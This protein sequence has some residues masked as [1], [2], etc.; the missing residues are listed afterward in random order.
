MRMGQGG[1]GCDGVVSKRGAMDSR[2]SHAVGAATERGLQCENLSRGCIEICGQ[3]RARRHS[4]SPSLEF[5]FYQ[6][7]RCQMPLAVQ[8]WQK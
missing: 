7:L 6:H 8:V 3:K 2:V 4:H 5:H 1:K